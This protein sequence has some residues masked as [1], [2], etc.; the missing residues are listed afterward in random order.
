MQQKDR[1]ELRSRFSCVERCTLIA[2]TISA[3]RV[4]PLRGE[5]QVSLM[6]V[7]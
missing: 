5:S 6:L 7:A 2:A 3:M 1:L 4:H